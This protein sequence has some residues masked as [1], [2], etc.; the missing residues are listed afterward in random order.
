ML[1]GDVDVARAIERNPRRIVETRI[2]TCSVAVT[3][4]AVASET[5]QR[6]DYTCRRD[7]AHGVIV[8]IGNVDIPGAI[9]RG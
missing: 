7:F 4:L 3:S 6:G 9:R 8:E 2:H 5:S 1:F